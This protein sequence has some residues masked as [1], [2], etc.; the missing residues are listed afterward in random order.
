M[1]YK[2]I[3]TTVFTPLE[4]SSIGVSEEEAFKALGK[5]HVKVFHSEFQALEWNLDSNNM[6][7]AYMKVI[8]NTKENNRVIGI[9]ILS[10][11][12]GELMQ[13]FAVAFNLGM[14]KEQLDDC[15]GIHPTCAE[16]M[17]KVT[18]DKALGNGKKED[19]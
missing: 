17:T 10:P 15:V 19:C 7:N 4:Y 14:T 2:N 16:E 9:H 18:V 13:G 1:N 12:S 5:E 8:I 6:D 11:N 3:P